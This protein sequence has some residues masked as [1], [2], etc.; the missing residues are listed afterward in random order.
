MARAGSYGDALAAIALLFTLAA[1][2]APEIGAQRA[3][4]QAMV[5]LNDS[6]LGQIRGGF[7][8]S[9]NLAVSFGFQQITSIDHQIVS[10]IVVPTF[11][12][13]P[14]LGHGPDLTALNSL[15]S[16]GGSG[17]SA[18]GNISPNDPPAGSGSGG[19]S[20]HSG[21][22]VQNALNSAFMSSGNGNSSNGTQPLTTL[23]NNTP[24][25]QLSNSQTTTV[26]GT[27]GQSLTTIMTQ[28]GGGGLTN[29]IQNQANNRIV[30][31]LTSINLG[32]SGL[33]SL[34]SQHSASTAL[35][36]ALSMGVGRFH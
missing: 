27:Q 18:A 6:Q 1:C 26:I 15:G 29:I 35:T 2:G 13:M 30:Q 14:S 31:Q 16:S 28:L 10:N 4:S 33:G 19:N 32:I 36:N 20:A 5:A 23:A 24:S 7:D 3:S 11:T 22:L 25:N 9:P 21:N 17:T 8:L 12:F 34:M